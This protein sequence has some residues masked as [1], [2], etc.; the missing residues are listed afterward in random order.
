MQ[1]HIDA[2]GAVGKRAWLAR[3]E[4][5]DSILT[6]TPA[7]L[8]EEFGSR[9]RCVTPQSSG[10]AATPPG[11]PPNRSVPHFP[12]SD[13]DEVL[14]RDQL[15]AIVYDHGARSAAEAEAFGG[16]LFWTLGAGGLV[17]GDHCECLPVSCWAQPLTPS[18]RCDRYCV[19]ADPER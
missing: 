7:M 4:P 3:S 17:D 6:P 8:V 18:R 16:S 10:R 11:P 1:S 19:Y 9:T 13:V 15:Y 12:L 5:A 2:A 14:R